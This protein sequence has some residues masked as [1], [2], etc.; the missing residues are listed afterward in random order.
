[1]NSISNHEA[2]CQAMMNPAFYPHAVRRVERRDTHISAVFLTGQWAYKLKKPVDFGF[3]DFTTRSAR[4]RFCRREVQLN[5]RLSRNI[6]IGVNEIFRDDRGRWSMEGKGRAEDYIVQMRQLPDEACL[7]EL[8]KNKK[9]KH[10]H[11]IQLSAKL[12]DF[13]NQSEPD[14]AIRRYGRKDVISFNMEENFRQLEPFQRNFPEDEKWE[15]ICQVCRSFLKNRYELLQH[16]LKTDRVRDGHGDLRTDHIYFTDDLQIIDC[17]EFNDRFRYGDAALDLAFLKMDLETQGFPEWS[18]VL[19]AAY[20][21]KADD[22]GLYTVVDYYAAY[23]SIVRLKVVFMQFSEAETGKSEKLKS[24]AASYLAQAYRY[25]VQFSRPTIWILCGLPA[26][27][28]STLA[29]RLSANLFI[30]LYHSDFLRK[31]EGPSPKPQVVQYGKGVYSQGKRRKV[32]AL[33][34]ERAHATLK[35]GR[36]VILDATFADQKWRDEARQLAADMDA[37]I[38]F[39][40]CTCREKTIRRRLEQREELPGVSDARKMHLPKMKAAYV[41]FNGYQ[42]EYHLR[43]DT[44]LPVREAFYRLLSAGYYCQWSQVEAMV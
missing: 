38:V 40:E 14:P 21:D 3:L 17:I 26:T 5:R 34:L 28:K 43:V 2:I 27:G 22:P 1:M 9:I 39:A 19:L 31:R 30:P 36:S 42:P 23:R 33:L 20:V 24:E 6:Y 4:S 10:F 8:L 29:S 35:N 12:A 13:Y 16:R 11:M 25:A 32:Y 7:T 41:S 37:N 44:D 15:F 18:R